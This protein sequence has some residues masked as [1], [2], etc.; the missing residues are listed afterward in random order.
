MEDF[1]IVHNSLTLPPG[2]KPATAETGCFAVFDGHGGPS[3]ASFCRDHL[4]DEITRQAGFWG[5]D[6]DG[7]VKAIEEGFLATH[8]LT[9]AVVGL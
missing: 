4:V 3:A 7:V 2:I 1:L 5:A 9:W 8:R 6:E